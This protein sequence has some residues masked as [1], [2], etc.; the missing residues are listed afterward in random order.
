[1]MKG[2]GRGP[3]L[4]WVPFTFV[5]EALFC[6]SSSSSPLPFVVSCVSVSFCH[7]ASEDELNMQFE[8]SGKKLSFFV[9]SAL[10]IPIVNLQTL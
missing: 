3:T 10:L 1:M 6:D 5:I 4:D 8:I 2:E 7:S 9:S